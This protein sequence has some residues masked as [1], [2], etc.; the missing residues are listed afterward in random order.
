MLAAR[1][2]FIL[3]KWTSIQS[4]SL[5]TYHFSCSTKA[6]YCLQSI[7][8]ETENVRSLPENG[9]LFDP[10][11]NDAFFLEYNAVNEYHWRHFQ[12]NR[13]MHWVL[14]DRWN[15]LYT[16]FLYVDIWIKSKELKK[17][18]NTL[19][20]YKSNCRYTTYGMRILNSS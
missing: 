20:T 12:N 8:W 6:V 9:F 10:E 14:L 15:I 13:K 1:F 11:F 7:K 19:H 4:I 2:F 17:R 16:C 18:N 3:V 5:Y